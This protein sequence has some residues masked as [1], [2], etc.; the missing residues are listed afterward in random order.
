WI[1]NKD[2]GV[3][4]GDDCAWIDL[5]TFPVSIE[6]LMVNAGADELIC[7]DQVLDIDNAIAL[8]HESLQW[9]S[10]GDG[11]F[12]ETDIINPTYTPGAQDITE[13]E[14]AL[15]I[16]ATSAE[17]TVSDEMVVTIDNCDAI[18]KSDSSLE[19]KVYPNPAESY[20]IFDLSHNPILHPD[21]EILIY[22]SQGR[23]IEQ[24]PVG[25]KQYIEV[26][27]QKFSS[28]IYLYILKSSNSIGKV[29]KLI[30]R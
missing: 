18:G 28:G 5:I 24:I 13:G 16:I 12:N 17:Q 9:T 1:Y 15:T 20:V 4:N 22:N 19:L 26:D 7:N 25:S 27:T 10:S 3:S 6:G 23:I 29:E 30:I 21:A 14:V 11:S 2:S 8:N